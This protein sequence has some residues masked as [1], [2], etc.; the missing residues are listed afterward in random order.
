MDL[1]YGYTRFF[2]FWKWC[3]ITTIIPW[4]NL[5]IEFDG[6]SVFFILKV[7]QRRSSG[8]LKFTRGWDEYRDGFGDLSSTGE[9]WLGNEK[10][11]KL[12]ED[13]DTKWEIQVKVR[14]SRT[15]QWSDI[16]SNFRLSGENYTLHVDG[17]IDCG[18]GK[19]NLPNSITRLVFYVYSVDADPIEIPTQCS[20]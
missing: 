2:C 15:T 10:V 13:Q 7:I 11:R 1:K 12:T 3:L 9:F 14:D 8:D 6:A 17:S 5:L 16:I 20:L 19:H 4:L 18:N